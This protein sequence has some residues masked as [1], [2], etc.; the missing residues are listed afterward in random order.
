MQ[1]IFFDTS[2]Q[3]SFQLSNMLVYHSYGSGHKLDRLLLIFAIGTLYELREDN[4]ECRLASLSLGR[5]PMFERRQSGGEQGLAFGRFEMFV[6][7]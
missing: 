7:W 5:T 2:R 4:A 6:V 1:R 3:I